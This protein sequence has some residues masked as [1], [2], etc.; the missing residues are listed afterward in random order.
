MQGGGYP[1]EAVRGQVFFVSPRY[2]NLRYI[3]EGAYGMV[4]SAVDNLRRRRVAIKKINPF[5]NE[6]SGLKALREIMI[7]SHLEHENVIGILDIV[8]APKRGA[9]HDL[10]IVQPLMDMDLRTLLKN[11]RLPRE[12]ACCFFYQILRGLKYIHSANV[13][14]LD[15]KPGNVLVNSD[16]YLKI[17]DFGL[18]R[19]INPE[20]PNNDG[21]KEYVVTRWY[22]APEVMLRNQPF[23]SKAVDM[24]SVGCILAEMLSNKPL[25]PG[26]HYLDELNNIFSVIGSPSAED[27]EN[28]KG[29]D[30]KRHIA[31]LPDKPKVP[32][33]QL[34]PGTEPSAL[35]VLDRMIT[36]NPKNRITVEQALDH[37][38]LVR[39]HDGANEPVASEPF[40]FET[41]FDDLPQHEIKELIRLEAARYDRR[42]R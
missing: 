18:A 27:L 16:C 30:S 23:I 6:T 15:L 40:R 41:E 37:Q 38:Y 42:R 25:F 2:T 29:A 7:L 9:I 14:H 13:V 3:S 24:W 20:Q 34:F 26:R 35:D 8:R 4:C 22:R 1:P 32:L 19:M 36:F 28:I 39:Y 17:C 11:Q 33:K 31:S 21:L 10:Y 12:H 5:N